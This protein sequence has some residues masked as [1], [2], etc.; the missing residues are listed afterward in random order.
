MSD[1]QL[2]GPNRRRGRSLSIPLP[3]AWLAFN[4]LAFALLAGLV[5]AD[6]EYWHWYSRTPTEARPVGGVT[7]Q[8]TSQA[9]RV[10]GVI[11]KCESA[12]PN[13]RLDLLGGCEGAPEYLKVNDRLEVTVRTSSG[14]SYVVTVPPDTAVRVGDRWPR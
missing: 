5:W 1:D 4:L 10:V 12:N 8:P 14:G 13:V 7:P 2:Q 11:R 3:P 9:D 6:R